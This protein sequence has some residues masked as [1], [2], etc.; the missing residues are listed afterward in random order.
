MSDSAACLEH[1]ASGNALFAKGEYEAAAAAYSAALQTSPGAATVAVLRSNRA[2]CQ[3]QLGKPQL[4]LEDALAAAEADPGYTKAL[5]RLAAAHAALGQLAKA[6]RTAKRGAEEASFPALRAQLA[7]AASDYKRAVETE[8]RDLT[9]QLRGLA[10]DKREAGCEKKVAHALLC[11]GCGA[12]DKSTVTGVKRFRE[13]RRCRSVSYCSVECAAEHWYDGHRPVCDELKRKRD[14]ILTAGF[15]EK[16]IG[17]SACTDTVKAFV[18]RHP[19]HANALQVLAFVLQ[20]MADPPW[21]GAPGPV[22]LELLNVEQ[23]TSTKPLV[24][25]AWPLSLLKGQLLPKAKEK[26]G[27]EAHSFMQDMISALERVDVDAGYLLIVPAVGSLASSAV[28][29]PR[30]R[31]SFPTDMLMDLARCAEANGCIKIGTG[32]PVMASID[33]ARFLAAVE[34]WEGAAAT[35]T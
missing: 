5:L 19:T 22:Q 12:L 17:R 3:L 33:T 25:S 13:C 31:Y 16:D 24:V 10:A 2:A 9:E 26:A 27:T 28:A 20:H 23:L 34:T 7:K 35:S 21:G 4:A 1:R 32:K 18:Q 14:A 11:Q 8:V 6:H 15:A 29:N 30:M